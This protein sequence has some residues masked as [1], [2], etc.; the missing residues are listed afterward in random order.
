MTHLSLSLFGRGQVLLGDEPVLGFRT[1]KVQALLAYLAA[2]PTMPHRRET[3]M[4]LLWPGMPD[5]SARA[6]LRQILFLLRQTIPDFEE[7]GNSIPLLIA[8]RDTLQLNPQAGVESDLAQLDALLEQVKTHTHIALS[9][10][11]PCHQTLAAAVAL[12][13]GDFLADFYLDDSNE[14]EAWAETTRQSYRR[15]VLDALETLTTLA[16]HQKAYADARKYAERQLEMDNLRES[17]YRQLMETLALNGQRA[18]ALALYETC[19]RLFTEELGM[20]P[21]TRTTELYEKIL[22]GDLRFDIPHAQGIR[23]Y[24]LQEEIGSGA[25]GTI[26][27]AVQPAIGREVAVKIIRSRF[28]ND[29]AFIR[30]FET[31]AQTI[32]RL[33][34]PHIVPLY[35][36]W[37]EANGA[38]LVMRLLRGGNLLDALRDGPWQPARVQTFLDQMAP[39]LDAA[40][41]QGIV[42][43]DLKP[44]NILFDETGNAYLSDF[45]IAKDLKNANALTIEGEILGT[46]DY[47]SPE[48]LQDAPVS[49]QTDI[50]SLGAVIYEMLTG[51]KP[52]PN[53]PLI[54]LI[55][56]HL[57]VSLPPVSHARPHLP[58]QLDD[59]I[60]RAT[61]KNPVDR[62]A[63]VLEMADAFRRAIRGGMSNLPE[64]NTVLP[65]EHLPNPY[66]GLRPYQ[67]ADA[68][69]FFGRETLITQLV[70]QIAESRFVAVVGPSGSGKSSV[71]KAGLLPALRGGALPGSD[72]WYITEMVPG[73]HPLEELELALWPVAVNPPVSLVEPMEKDTR[74]MLRTIRRILPDEEDVQLFLVIDQFEELFTLVEDEARRTHFLTSLLTAVTA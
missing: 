37:R 36:Y 51:E 40:H 16:I 68:P 35:D 55:Q 53:V 39:A 5:E 65:D 70:H 57:M 22:A 3:L 72:R 13:Q 2:R 32:A 67:E 23:G 60:Q 42:H 69:D 15:K 44:A 25:Y 27:R 11:L 28:A 47:I 43:R 17:A 1:K 74:G 21:S 19:R 64:P 59:V 7:H 34:H 12:Y 45:G 20:T 49:P 41:R 50:Y 71:V 30:R 18:E 9:T 56:N 66:K 31:E 62:F 26:H 48:Q 46:P 29:P 14:F 73:T 63:S 61:A 6:N 4:A 58:L 24:E 8:N 54:T 38:Y 10:C 33:E 52:F